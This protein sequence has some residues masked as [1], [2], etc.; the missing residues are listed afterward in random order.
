[1]SE[2]INCTRCNVTIQQFTF[3]KNNGLCAPCYQKDFNQR[4]LEN[5]L[6]KKG[7][8]QCENG[9]ID[10]DGTEMLPWDKTTLENKDLPYQK[11]PQYIKFFKKLKSGDLFQCSECKSF[12]YYHPIFENIHLLSEEK[13]NYLLR[14]NQKEHILAEWQIEF[15]SEIGTYKFIDY[16]SNKPYYQS[17]ACQVYTKNKYYPKAIFTFSNFPPITSNCCE[18]LFP[19]DIIKIEKSEYALSPFLINLTNNSMEIQMGVSPTIV[20]DKKGNLFG[21]NGP[22]SFFYLDNTKGCDLIDK[23]IDFNQD[24]YQIPVYFETYDD[25]VEISCD[26]NFPDIEKLEIKQ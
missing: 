17:I 12:W 21:I 19:E 25:I 22:A 23:Q 11:Y 13:Y 4:L 7:C 20:Q 8:V 15:L 6:K 2:K 18:I 14:W 24:H 3:E 1:M 10:I 16:Y 9:H 5:L 26:L